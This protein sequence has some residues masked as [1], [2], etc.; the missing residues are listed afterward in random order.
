MTGSDDYQAVVA[1]GEIDPEFANTPIVL[2]LTEDGRSLAEEGPRLV[3]PSDE[4]GGR[5]VSE[6]VKIRVKRS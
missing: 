3:V 6:V 2:A 1:W 5:Y 4:R